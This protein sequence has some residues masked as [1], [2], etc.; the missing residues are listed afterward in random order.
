M[1]AARSVRRSIVRPAARRRQPRSS[2]SRTGASAATDASVIGSS[3]EL[4][5]AD[6]LARVGA[7][8]LG[9]LVRR[10]L[11]RR[12]R[13]A[14]GRC[15]PSSGPCRRAAGRGRRPSAR[16]SAGSRPAA[17]RGRRR[18]PSAAA[19]RPPARLPVSAYHAFHASTYGQR[20]GE[21]PRRRSSRS[22]AAGRPAAPAAAAAPRRAPRRTRPRSRSRPSASSVRTIV[23]DSSKRRDPVV[24]RR[25][26]RR[27]L[28]RRSSRRRCPGPAGRPR[29][30]RP[31]R[32]AWR[33]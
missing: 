5:V 19:R 15:R 18:R 32:P 24:E 22:A 2:R 10:A 14:S 29:S 1:L 20:R 8:R 9:D 16:S 11:E 33:A 3:D 7:Q 6:A 30:R 25:A 26:E 28:G 4:D 12:D 31:S 17:A 23:N 21:H 27:E 13:P